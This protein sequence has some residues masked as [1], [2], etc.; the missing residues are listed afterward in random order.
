MSQFLA[1]I[2][3]WLFNKIVILEDIEKEIEEH[4]NNEDITAKHKALK[5]SIGDYLPDAPLAEL[6]DESNIHGWLQD[7]IT[8]A[9]SR[10]AGLIG[11]I[12]NTKDETEKITQIYRQAGV[13][14]A[15]A[16][17]EKVDDPAAIFKGLNDVLLEGMPCDRVNAIL[18]QTPE[19]FVW[20]TAQCVHKDNWEN[21]GVDVT[22]FYGFREALIDGYVSEISNQF[23]Y[24]YD[25]TNEQIHTISIN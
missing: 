3:T 2:H 14:A 25:N 12:I 18:E 24:N 8:R 6:I 21:N 16:I 4:Y 9:E 19:R 17:G 5:A 11:Q 22:Y 1:P 23:V 15:Q 7:R 20:K 10:Q 13:K